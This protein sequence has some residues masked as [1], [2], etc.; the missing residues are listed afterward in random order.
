MIYNIIKKEIPQIN[1]IVWNTNVINEFTLHY[2]INNYNV[3]E[4]EKIAIDLIVNLLKEKYLKKI[5]IYKLKR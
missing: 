4:V 1:F 5:N 2:V 3:I